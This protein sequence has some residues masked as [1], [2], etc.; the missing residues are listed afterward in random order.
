MLPMG[1]L[2]LRVRAIDQSWEG[3]RPQ[4]ANDAIPVPPS[5]ENPLDCSAA[6]RPLCVEGLTDGESAPVEVAR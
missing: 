1:F 5:T 3:R 6:P 2:V 4:L